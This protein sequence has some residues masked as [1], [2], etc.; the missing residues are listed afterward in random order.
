MVCTSINPYVRIQVL[1]SKYT[2][3]YRNK[4]QV[5]ILEE[6]NKNL[7]D[8]LTLPSKI[9]RGHIDAGEYFDINVTIYYWLVGPFLRSDDISSVW[10]TN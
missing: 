1:C 8:G 10:Y 2:E 6:C 5:R 3:Q 4:A 9:T 7:E